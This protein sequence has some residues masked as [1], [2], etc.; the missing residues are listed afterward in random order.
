MAIVDVLLFCGCG[1]KFKSVDEAA[2]H[3]DEK[4]HTI[5]AQ[6]TIQPSTRK[7]KTIHASPSDKARPHVRNPVATVSPLAAHAAEVEAVE[8]EAESG[9]FSDLRARLRAQGKM[10]L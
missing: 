9:R 3:A 7:A 1:R 5:N 4:G 8:V 10:R 6:G 2:K